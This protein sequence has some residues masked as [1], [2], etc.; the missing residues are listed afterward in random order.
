MTEVAAIDLTVLRDRLCAVLPQLAYE[1]V[2]LQHSETRDRTRALSIE[3]EAR[4]PGNMYRMTIAAFDDEV[5]FFVH[6]HGKSRDLT[7]QGAD[8][9]KRTCPGVDELFAIVHS[10]WTASAPS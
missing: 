2:E 5:H 8:R 4:A 3:T 9:Y 1:L 6:V 10:C 7:T